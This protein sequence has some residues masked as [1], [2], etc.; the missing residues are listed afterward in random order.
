MERAARRY[1]GALSVEGLRDCD[2]VM[3]IVA[4]GC[5]PVWHLFVV[6]SPNRE[7]L[8]GHLTRHDVETLIHYPVAPYLQ[9]AYASLG[10]SQGRFPITERLQKEIFSVSLFSLE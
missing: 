2:V 8:R 10:F 5:T 9:P 3:P 6:C 7:A 4:P 1:C